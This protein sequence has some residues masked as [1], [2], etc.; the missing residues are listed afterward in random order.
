MQQI[1][2]ICTIM[3]L[4]RDVNR[5]RNPWKI[6]NGNRH[7]KVKLRYVTPSGRPRYKRGQEADNDQQRTP[8]SLQTAY[9]NKS[10]HCSQ[11]PTGAEHGRS[12]KPTPPT[13]HPLSDAGPCI[14]WPARLMSASL[15]FIAP[16]ITTDATSQPEFNCYLAAPAAEACDAMQWWEANG[17][18]FRNTARL[19][20]QYLSVPATSA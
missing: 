4:V 15:K 3:C 2:Q 17:H 7:S 5:L 12:F 16:G 14:G 18:H 20:K 11:P 13:S 6:I 9:V 8:Q 1:C 10:S 19:A